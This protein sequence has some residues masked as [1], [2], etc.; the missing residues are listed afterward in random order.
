[1][2]MM[3]MMPVTTLFLDI[4]GVLLTNG[5]DHNSRKLAA[6]HFGLDPVEMNGLHY[7]TFDIYESGKITLD[8]YLSRVVFYRKRTFTVEQF[9][10]FMFAQSS[11]FPQM[12]EMVGRLK[13]RYGLKIAIVSN[14]G[15]ELN[16]FRM[17]KFK[18]G[19]LVDCFISSCFVGIR[20]PDTRMY[21][22][23]LD[24]S[25]TPASQALY[26]ENIPMFV[27]V[28]ESLGIRGII[29]TDYEST[30]KKL[31]AFGL[32]TGESVDNETG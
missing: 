24:I 31:A 4:G 32:R 20:K 10:D 21:L 6:K 28:A 18:L 19:Q 29:H 16:A 12:L 26:I 15:R 1:M 30:C 25:S 7:L 22:L 9:R 3:E 14:E 2:Q 13:Q 5:W 17:E 8:E 23:A 11:P 27:Q